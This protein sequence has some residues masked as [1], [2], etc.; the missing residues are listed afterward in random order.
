MNPEDRDSFDSDR[1]SFDITYNDRLNNFVNEKEKIAQQNA[2]LN[3]KK[4]QKNARLD[5]EERNADYTSDNSIRTSEAMRIKT[6]SELKKLWTS[7]IDNL[8]KISDNLSNPLSKTVITENGLLIYI[9]PEGRLNNLI[10][11]IQDNN[12]D[13]SRDVIKKHNFDRSN[14][15]YGKK[16]TP[17]PKTVSTY[18]KKM[19]GA[20]IGGNPEEEIVSPDTQS[21][22]TD[23]AIPEVISAEEQILINKLKKLWEKYINDLSNLR[24]FLNS[25]N[26]L[27]NTFTNTEWII[28]DGQFNNLINE[29]KNLN[30]P[31]ISP[32]NL[33]ILNDR[34]SDFK[35]KMNPYST[36][37]TMSKL[38]KKPI[39][40]N[41]LNS[42]KK[43]RK[44]DDHGDRDIEG[45]RKT[46]K[47]RKP[48][49]P[50]RTR[51]TRKTRKPRKGRRTNKR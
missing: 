1:D 43:W 34:R 49:K 51:K 10:K 11:S 29:M 7:Y 12:I 22:Q 37:T 6:E 21:T 9:I 33:Q 44:T 48:R 39:L 40:S 15:I 30:I 13:I 36:S 5:N 28:P 32:E 24:N 8:K 26:Y 17:I 45:G 18:W 4:A 14:A 16:N 20:G 25:P 31:S 50:R 23:I 27:K 35:A 46:R 42:W 2:M 3:N 38:W 47:A 41:S 19:T